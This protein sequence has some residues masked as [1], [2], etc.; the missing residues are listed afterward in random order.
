MGLLRSQHGEYDNE[1]IYKLDW[2]IWNHW[3]DL[4]VFFGEIIWKAAIMQQARRDGVM[5]HL[6]N[7][8][9]FLMSPSIVNFQYFNLMMQL[10]FP[11][12]QGYTQRILWNQ[13]IWMI[14]AILRQDLIPFGFQMAQWSS[15]SFVH[16]LQPGSFQSLFMDDGFNSPQRKFWLAIFWSAHVRKR[17]SNF[18]IMQQTYFNLHIAS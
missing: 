6:L 17:R 12:L 15:G 14:Y 3:I 7:D 9:I 2:E 1:N 13:L 16:R 10:I 5:I 11:V 4:H 8:L 18:P